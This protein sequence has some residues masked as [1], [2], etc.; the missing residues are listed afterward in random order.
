[1][2]RVASEMVEIGGVLHDATTHWLVRT[3]LGLLPEKHVSMLNS[4]QLYSQPEIYTI[5]CPFFYFRAAR[6][7]WG[8]VS[9]R[10]S[11]S[12]ALA[13]KRGARGGGQGVPGGLSSQGS[14]RQAVGHHIGGPQLK[15]RR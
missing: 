7:T 1:M 14:K 4:S 12:G 5:T 10:N 3:K 8:T 9:S 2:L 11:S 6:G 13:S 15:Q